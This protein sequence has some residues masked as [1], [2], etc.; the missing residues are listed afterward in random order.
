[1]NQGIFR[2]CSIMPGLNVTA[3]LGNTS[4]RLS[5][6]RLPGSEDAEEL[7]REKTGLGTYLIEILVFIHLIPIAYGIFVMIRQ[8]LN[9]EMDTR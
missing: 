2:G 1:M 5:H 4:A 3:L 7:E 6:L 8:S 9:A